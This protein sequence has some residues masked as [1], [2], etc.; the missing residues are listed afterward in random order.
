MPRDYAWTIHFD[1]REAN[2][3]WE[4]TSR[5]A[6]MSLQA[7][8]YRHMRESIPTLIRDHYATRNR[9]VVVVATDNEQCWVIIERSHL[10]KLVAAA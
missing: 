5:G 9:D 7:G 8:N 4:A 6:S 1:F 2:G 3:I 10:E